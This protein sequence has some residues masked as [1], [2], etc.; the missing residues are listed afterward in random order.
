METTRIPT[1]SQEPNS[2]EKI[3]PSINGVFLD[4]CIYAKSDIGKYDLIIILKPKKFRTVIAKDSSLALTRNRSNE[5][6][7]TIKHFLAQD[8]M[9]QSIL[10]LK[11]DDLLHI[12]TVISGYDSEENRKTIYN[13][14]RELV[15]FLSRLDF[16]FDF[17]LIEAEEVEEILSLGAISIFKR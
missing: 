6:F 1:Y 9:V 3:F 8:E 13:R 5:L 15:N 10:F 14:E 12:W 2:S 11:K 16:H 4:E 17:Y 7:A